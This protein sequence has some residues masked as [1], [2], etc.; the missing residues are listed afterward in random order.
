MC[1]GDGEL[2]LVVC[3]SYRID[4]DIGIRHTF[5]TLHSEVGSITMTHNT[6]PIHR[7]TNISHSAL[8]ASD[9]SNSSIGT[10]NS[11]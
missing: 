1:A 10:W 2:V 11:E 4:L 9:G 6:Q 8:N 3:A 5:S 7:H